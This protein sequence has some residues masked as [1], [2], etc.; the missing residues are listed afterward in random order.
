VYR[1]NDLGGFKGT[2]LTDNINLDGLAGIALSPD[3][4]KFFVTS[5]GNNRVMSYDYNGVTGTAS[6]PTVF[7]DA[8]DGLSSPYGIIF[9]Q[10]R[11]RIF[12]SNLG[13]TGV[14]QFNLDG[15]LAGPPLT[16]TISG[17]QVSDGMGGVTESTISQFA[18]MGIA[19]DGRLQVAGYQNTPGGNRG[20]V[21][22]ANTSLTF[23]TDFLTPSVDL[24]G[25][26]ALAYY[27]P[28]N[29]LFVTGELSGRMRRFDATT[30]A[31][32]LA[33]TNN[34]PG[35]RSIAVFGNGLVLIGVTGNL[36]GG[37]Y[38]GTFDT[39]GGKLGIGVF[40]EPAPDRFHEATVML[41][42]S[43][44]PSGLIASTI[45]CGVLLPVLRRSKKHESHVKVERDSY[46]AF[47]IPLRLG[48]R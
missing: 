46:S 19:P 18:G 15:T 41:I 29:Y 42:I 48:G 9:S 39:N 35:P 14:A 44:E 17:G 31:E 13:G 24:N 23:L 47:A 32:Q 25:A 8:S 20:T 27:K 11:S 37:G 28:G 34:L 2:V 36:P 45:A 33:G 43:P 16:G 21:A 5:T 10:D 6:N 26:T 30:G 38:I 7:A 1:Y 40:A 4:K 22:R 3:L 12:V